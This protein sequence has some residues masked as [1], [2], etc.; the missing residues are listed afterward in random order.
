M[1]MSMRTFVLQN[2]VI[3]LSNCGVLLGQHVLFLADSTKSLAL[4]KGKLHGRS[5]STDKRLW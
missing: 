3:F 4:V 1:E 2:Q 5:C